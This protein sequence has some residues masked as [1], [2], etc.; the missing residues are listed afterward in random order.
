MHGTGLNSQTFRTHEVGDTDYL[1]ITRDEHEISVSYVRRAKPIV[2]P[3]DSGITDAMLL[4][5]KNIAGHIVV[6]DGAQHEAREILK[7]V[8]W[9][10]AVVAEFMCERIVL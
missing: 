9:R 10:F 3:K 4:S 2:I 5:A 8:S 1:E 6:T 7:T